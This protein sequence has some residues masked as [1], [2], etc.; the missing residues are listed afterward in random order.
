MTD[1]CAS[2]GLDVYDGGEL[3]PICRGD[4]PSS[5]AANGTNSPVESSTAASLTVLQRAALDAIAEHGGVVD[6]A[7]AL[8]CNHGIISL[9]RDGND[10]PKARCV[11]GLPPKTVE[12]PP[13]P[14]CGQVHEVKATCTDKLRKRRA[15]PNRVRLHYEAGY[16]DEGRAV[17][18]E[19]RDEMRAAGCESFTEWV[20]KLREKSNEGVRTN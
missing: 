5:V 20:D 17:D 1:R 3:C 2:C 6:A 12:V 10:F 13:C 16:G 18:V 9:A 11:L 14:D 4:A 7:R 15:R 19:I 8:G